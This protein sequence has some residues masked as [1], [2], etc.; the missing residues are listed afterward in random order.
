MH[1][2]YKVCINRPIIGS[3]EQILTCRIDIST[4]IKQHVSTQHSQDSHSRAEAQ[5]EDPHHW[6]KV[7]NEV[8]WV[9]Q[10]SPRNTALLSDCASDCDVNYRLWQCSLI[11]SCLVCDLTIVWKWFIFI[12]KSCVMYNACMFDQLFIKRNCNVSYI[13]FIKVYMCNVYKKNIVSIFRLFYFR[14]YRFWT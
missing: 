5:A 7:S 13:F 14:S 4:I 2:I 1:Y 11:S 12:M 10:P 9:K 8:Q 6:N 3:L